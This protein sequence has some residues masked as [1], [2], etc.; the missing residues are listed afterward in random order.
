M[1]NMKW[2]YGCDLCDWKKKNTV[3]VV[4]NCFSSLIGTYKNLPGFIQDL[5]HYRASN[6]PK[7]QIF[8]TFASKIT[9]STALY[10]QSSCIIG[11]KINT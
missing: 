8:Q 5:F 6:A 2:K 10:D 11:Y 9:K 7:Q 1:L 3:L 4:K